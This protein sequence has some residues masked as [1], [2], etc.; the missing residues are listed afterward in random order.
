MRYATLALLLVLTGMT[1]VS[2][3]KAHAIETL[4]CSQQLKV[5]SMMTTKWTSADGNH[6]FTTTLGET[7]PTETVAQH[8]ARHRAGLAAM[9]DVFEPI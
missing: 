5:S 7:D 8:A 3:Y 2:V 6:E 4:L 1:A 9:Q